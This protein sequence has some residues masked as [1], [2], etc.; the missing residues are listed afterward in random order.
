MRIDR[1]SRLLL[2]AHALVFAVSF[3]L[4]LALAAWLST[5]FEI[6]AQWSI[7]GRADLSEATVTLLQRMEEPVEMV[8]FVRPDD[9]LA[10]HVHS[11]AARYQ[12]HKPDLR[13]RAVNPDSRPDLVRDFGI[14]GS[15]EIIL[16]YR[17]R[18]ERI[19]VPSE[20]RLSA[21]LERLLRS[22]G[23]PIVFITGHGERSL[24]G[25]ANHDL[26]SFGEYL[27]ERG[28]Q[29]QP[30]DV[31][32]DVPGDASM[33]V[34]AGPR[35]DWLPG[36]RR[37]AE[38]YLDDGGN[39]L[40]LVDDQDDERLGFLARRLALTLLPGVIVE[41]RAEELLGVD[42]PRML[43]LGNNSRHPALRELDGISLFVSARALEPRGDEQGEG[44]DGDSGDRPWDVS[45]LI[46]T[47]ARHWA[48][49]SEP[50]QPE[51]DADA[52]DR[53]GPL[54]VGLGLSRPH[55]AAG[56]R[57][58]SAEQRIVVMGDADFLSNAY[59][60]NGENLQLGLRLVDW[61]S[62]GEGLV[63]VHGRAAPDQRLDF[64]QR[65]LMAIGIAFLLVLP[66][67]FLAVA[68][69]LWW[70]RRRA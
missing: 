44:D 2:R 4:L 66:A 58:D 12:Q 62:A 48:D 33:L 39:L 64:E 68:G 52:G 53:R 19:R 38:R 35:T 5:R 60:G 30:I 50:E 47:E 15:G 37:L 17:G 29:L 54:A 6:A 49:T 31:G 70:R 26:G 55:P 41:P 65:T 1:R 14:E 10:D 18:Q 9:L 43:A 32:Q 56:N 57:D 61:L 34:V 3:L 24:L 27:R 13:Y 67:L 8:A 46:M 7:A 28:H 36:T 63:D 21:A 51:F 45:P 25:Q 40:W 23:R 20:P 69:V 11:L 16:E 42:D 22:D 59:L